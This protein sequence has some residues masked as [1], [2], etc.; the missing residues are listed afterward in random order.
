MFIDILKKNKVDIF[1][2]RNA[3]LK[4]IFNGNIKLYEYEKLVAYK[5][6]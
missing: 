2:N 1:D 6:K 3:Y 5:S 4:L